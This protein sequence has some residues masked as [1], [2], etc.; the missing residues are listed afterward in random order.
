MKVN[1]DL[2]RR[3]FLKSGLVS[4]FGG[5]VFI[6]SF[7][8]GEIINLFGKDKSEKK[9]KEKVNKIEYRR[10]GNIGYNASLLG[11]GA[12]ITTDPAVLEKALDMGIN[13]VDTARGYQR[14]NNEVMVG[15][16]IK[17]RRKEVFLTTK[18][19]ARSKRSILEGAEKSL[20]ALDTDYVDALLAHKLSS[21][22]QVL[23]EDVMSALEKLKKD[24][25]TR[26]VGVSTHSSSAE[27]INAMVDSKFYDLVTVKYSFRGDEEL[28]KAIE[29]A[30][31]AGI[32]VVAMKVMGGGRGYIGSK[33]GDLNPFQS[34]LKWVMNDKNIATT[35]PSITS[36]RQLNENFEVMGTKMT[37][38]DRKI[39]DKFAKAT[40]K[41]YCRMCG[42][43]LGK[44]PENV[45]IPDI[46][47]YLMYAEGYGELQL[48][49]DSYKSLSFNVN[50]S[51]C[52][53]CDYCVAKC[54][55]KLEIQKRMVHAHSL[56]A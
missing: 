48:G 54:V 30:N 18:E 36:F 3:K 37:W 53:D 9:E 2:D 29:R 46:M 7:N 22:G 17:K 32:A 31:K 11:F 39:L 52:I 14:G 35:I 4:V 1:K 19:S 40:D 12:M 5:G 49:R 44:C 27:V 50:A 47:R 24:G 41:L 25:K 13:Y 8:R 28:K 6:D 26:Y 38:S 20:K 15:K 42:E 23:D 51:K 43:C 21:R 56:L 16:V 34:A 33:M 45:N 55:N 10:L